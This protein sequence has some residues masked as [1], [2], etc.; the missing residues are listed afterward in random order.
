MNSGLRVGTLE[1]ISSRS[2]LKH[3]TD[4]D[5]SSAINSDQR[6]TAITEISPAFI[7]DL[8][9]SDILITR[10]RLVFPRIG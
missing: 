7:G 1:L 5:E 8:I 9:T 6:A 3:V 4:S 2:G 10:R